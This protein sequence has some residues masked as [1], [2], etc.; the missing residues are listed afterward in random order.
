MG[1]VINKEMGGRKRLPARDSMQETARKRLL[2]RDSPQETPHESLCGSKPVQVSLFVC[3][4]KF[5]QLSLSLIGP[6]KV[7]FV[8]SGSLS[9]VDPEIV[10]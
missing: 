10:Q 4:S 9:L 1:A 5:V 3:G 2:A 7:W 8:T 6:E